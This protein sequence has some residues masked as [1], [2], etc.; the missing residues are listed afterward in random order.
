MPSQEP[1]VPLT[2]IV[3]N[4]TRTF[5]LPCFEQELSA[6]VHFVCKYILATPLGHRLLHAR[7]A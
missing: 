6:L 7:Q 2:A 4:K 3:S 1:K 5:G